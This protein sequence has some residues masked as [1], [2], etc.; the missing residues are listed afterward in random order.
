MSSLDDEI[1]KA[2]AGDLQGLLNAVL[3]RYAVL[4]PDW[5]VNTISLRKSADRNTQLDQ[6]IN[7]IQKMKNPS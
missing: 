4:Y 7:M 5:E 3:K 6:V 1:A 2:D